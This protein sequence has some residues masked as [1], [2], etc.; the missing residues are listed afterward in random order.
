M[1]GP[2]LFV[3]FINGQPLYLNTQV[4]L[5]A[6][7]TTLISSVDCKCIEELKDTLSRKVSNVDDRATA[8]SCR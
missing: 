1:L 6:D 5:F 2:L 4:D 7:D 8:N 3:I